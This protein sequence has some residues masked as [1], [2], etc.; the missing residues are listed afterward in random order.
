MKRISILAG[1]AWLMLSG[2]SSAQLT[3][4]IKGGPHDLSS[5]S[6]L[7]NSNSTI[8]AQTCIFCHVPHGGSNSIPLWNRS[9][10]SAGSYSVYASTT[11]MQ[12]ETAANVVGGVSGACLSCHDGSIALDVLTNVNGVA[13]PTGFVTFSQGVN[14]KANYGNSGSGV[15]DIMTLA[16]TISN[17]L[18]FLGQDLRNDHPVAVSYD[19]AYSGDTSHYSN[20][21]ANAYLTAGSGNVK[22]PLYTTTGV[23]GLSVECSSCHASHDNTLGNFLRVANTGSQMCLGCHKK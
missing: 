6:A 15:K 18:P 13:K 3:S 8:D 17:P 9:N 23:T 5:G 4:V 21:G 16:G 1:L 10:P 11:L 22:L 20:R 12:T 2:I 7:T 19:T 14:S